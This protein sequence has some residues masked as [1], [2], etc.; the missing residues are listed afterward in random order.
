MI[1]RS[2]KMAAFCQWPESCKSSQLRFFHPM[3][4]PRSAPFPFR[5][6]FEIGTLRTWAQD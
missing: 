3:R 2:L 4:T 1:T 5:P 6:S